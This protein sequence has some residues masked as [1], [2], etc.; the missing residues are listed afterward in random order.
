MFPGINPNTVSVSKRPDIPCKPSICTGASSIAARSLTVSVK[1]PDHNG[2]AIISSYTIS[3]SPS[4]GVG[5]TGSGTLSGANSGPASVT[6]LTPF[7]N[8][9]VTVIA[10]N[11]FGASVPS[12]T[13]STKT[14]A[15]VPGVPV[16]TGVVVASTT[17]VT[18][19]YTAPANDNGSTISNYRAISCVGDIGYN[20]SAAG[21]TITVSGLTS[22][23][24]YN[25]KVRATNSIGSGG[26]SAP[27]SNIL[28]PILP[29]SIT[30]N[31]TGPTSWVVPPGVTSVSIVAVGRGGSSRTCASPRCIGG[32]GGGALVY[33][34][35]IAVSAGQTYTIA[36]GNASSTTVKLGTT[37]IILANSGGDASLA[38]G[39][40]G[41][42]SIA[43]LYGGTGGG[44]RGG[45]GGGGWCTI[46]AG[47][48][49]GGYAGAG[50]NGSG[51]YYP[52]SQAASAGTGGGG[53]GGRYG[54]DGGGG[55]GGVGLFG[56]GSN[57]AA[58]TTPG[59]NSG[60]GGGSGG[61]SGGS[62]ICYGG[63]GGQYGGGGGAGRRGGAGWKSGAVRI[64]WPGFGKTNRQ[65]P[66]T[67]VGTP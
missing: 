37:F 55:G 58:G 52:N 29:G 36:A 30:F 33:R 46:G 47:G 31:V 35:N 57:G 65:F 10:Q 13:W 42:Y 45:A 26:C 50:G 20:Y 7:T 59:S 32:G 21:G 22:A 8:Y 19:S 23:Q 12:S 34:N 53:G 6:P 43:N 63:G 1:K 60:G 66:S 25:F 48:G 38:G 15:D 28:M 17:S 56:Q 54:F 39:A 3:A 11:A 67:C 16:V 27:S 9:D 49:A 40:G 44:G 64:V 14:R 5:L 61:T 2:G 18:V 51:Y 4:G 62:G 41:V 24:T